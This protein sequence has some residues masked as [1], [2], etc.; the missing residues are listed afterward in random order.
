MHTTPR[1]AFVSRLTVVSLALAAA[2][3]AGP[4]FVTDDPEPVDY[5]HWEIYLSTQQ[6]HN[7]DGWSGTAPHLE[8]NYGVVPDVQLHVIAPLSY[9]R[10]VG[11]RTN[12]GYG[13]TE[14]G[15]KYRF[16]HETDT[17]PMIG[18][19][20]FIELPSGGCAHV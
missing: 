4:P 3:H 20:P 17:C 18:I 15:V 6:Y 9:D 14:L 1:P 8:I 16:V 7:A 10:P 13:D 19:F 5:K 11:G 12:Y 2:A